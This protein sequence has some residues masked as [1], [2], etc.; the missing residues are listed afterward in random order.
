MSDSYTCPS[1]PRTS[2]SSSRAFAIFSGLCN[3]T[4]IA[5]STLLDVVPI[6]A[7]NKSYSYNKEYENFLP[8]FMAYCHQCIIQIV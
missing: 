8:K 1:L 5:H 7:I 2:L 3:N 6:P 4:V